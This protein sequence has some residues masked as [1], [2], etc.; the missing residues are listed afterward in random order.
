MITHFRNICY[1]SYSG[2]NAK[3][4]KLT[5]ITLEKDDRGYYLAATYTIEDNHAIREINIPKIRL[6]LDN[7]RVSISVEHDPNACYRV[8][9]ANL[10]FGELP[11]DWDVNQDGQT[12]LYTEKILEEKYTEMTI[13]EIEKKLGHK[14]KIVNK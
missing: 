1:N 7:K 10:G 13:E 12:Y 11:L 6:G 4:V 9:Y 3:E 2:G 14:I 5:K 8:A